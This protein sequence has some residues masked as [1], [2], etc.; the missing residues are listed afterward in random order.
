MDRAGTWEP[1][2]LPRVATLQVPRISG[3][4]VLAGAPRIRRARPGGA[5]GRGAGGN[6]VNWKPGTLGIRA[7]RREGGSTR[8]RGCPECPR[9][10]HS[11]GGHGLP[12]GP[13]A[14]VPAEVR[15]CLKGDP[16]KCVHFPA[17]P[18]SARACRR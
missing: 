12:H 8:V 6:L 9:G 3:F 16:L 14:R 5:A 15:C 17:G 11:G 7:T 18:T 4:Q 10:A 13:A 1:E 2:N